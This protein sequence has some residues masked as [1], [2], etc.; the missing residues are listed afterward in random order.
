MYIPKLNKCPTRCDCIQ[1]IT[2]LWTALRVLGVDTHH[3]E[4]IQLYLQLLALV[5]RVCYHPLSYS[6]C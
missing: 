5:I 6:R 3:Q 1:F 4:L 2:Y